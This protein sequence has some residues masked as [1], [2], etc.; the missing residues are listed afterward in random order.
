MMPGTFWF[1]LVFVV[2]VPV[3]GY[4]VAFYAWR[5]CGFIEKERNDS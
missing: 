2:V 5:R 1:W 4:G 3:I